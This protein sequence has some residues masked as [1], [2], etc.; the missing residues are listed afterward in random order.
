MSAVT[1]LPA[2]DWPLEKRNRPVIHETIGRCHLHMHAR[3]P[4]NKHLGTI[5]PSRVNASVVIT[6]DDKVFLFGGFDKFTD[7][8]KKFLLRGNEAD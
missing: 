4:V 1:L 3:A 7:E 2:V 8:G 5:P 6:Q